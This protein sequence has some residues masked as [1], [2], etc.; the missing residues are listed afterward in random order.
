MATKSTIGATPE[1]KEE[2]NSIKTHRRQTY[3]DVV[4]DLIRGKIRPYNKKKK[5]NKKKKVKK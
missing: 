3:E 5:P 1:L 2:L 4:W